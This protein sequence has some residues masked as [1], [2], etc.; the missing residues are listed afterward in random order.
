M[1]IAV[2]LAASLLSVAAYAQQQTVNVD[3][4]GVRDQIAQTLN[5][6]AD[7][8]PVS[9]QVSPAVAAEVCKVSPNLFATQ[10]GANCAA[11]A[12]SAALNAAVQQ[13]LKG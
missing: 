13:R 2:I 4:S 9:V 11:K 8:I 12:T 7:R 1:R 5:V 10:D 3:V 6:P